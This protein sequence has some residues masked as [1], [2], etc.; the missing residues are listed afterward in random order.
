MG[1]GS[2][3]RAGNCEPIFRGCASLMAQGL[4]LCL[5]SGSCLEE[6]IGLLNQTELH[7]GKIILQQETKHL[8]E[9]FGG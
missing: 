8:Q 5:G 1:C 3:G 6:G 4:F 2:K 9:A 7:K